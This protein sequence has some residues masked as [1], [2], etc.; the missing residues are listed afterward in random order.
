VSGGIVGEEDW[1]TAV[2]ESSNPRTEKRRVF[3]TLTGSNGVII[4]HT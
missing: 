2:F 4:A 1:A 3:I